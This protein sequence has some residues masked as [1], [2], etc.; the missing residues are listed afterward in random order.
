MTDDSGFL[1]NG[2]A[3]PPGFSLYDGEAIMAA[4]EEDIRQSL[5]ILLSTRPGERVM[6]PQFGCNLQSF[7]FEK[8]NTTTIT[9]LRDTIETAILYHEPRIVLEEINVS[10]RSAPDGALVFDIVYIISATN[11]RSNMV[12]P[13][14]MHEASNVGI[15][16]VR[17]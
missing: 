14:Y 17:P 10:D 4:G 16:A 12:F 8:I 13:F 1:G 11:S 9:Y 6:Q 3:F 2:W 5:R 15:N 7:V